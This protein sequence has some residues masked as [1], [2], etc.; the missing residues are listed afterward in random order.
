MDKL[1]LFVNEMLSRENKYMA[2]GDQSVRELSMAWNNS[3]KM[4]WAV[5]RLC[6]N[7]A[8]IVVAEE[9]VDMIKEL[10]RNAE[11][12]YKSIPENER[13]SGRAAWGD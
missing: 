11:E 5:R 12:E 9:D 6:L 8:V 10:R 3:E 7:C 1:R 4:L 13:C 2:I